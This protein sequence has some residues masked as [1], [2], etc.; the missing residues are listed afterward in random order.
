M[1]TENIQINIREDGAREVVININNIGK[2]ADKTA[3]DVIMLNQALE[4]MGKV[5]NKIKGVSLGFI[6]MADNVVLLEARLRM[7]TRTQENFLKSQEDIYKISQQNNVGLKETSQL[8]I[9]LFE[10]IS[11]LGG[12][13]KEVSTIVDA[14][15]TTLRISGATTRE[16][17]SATLQFSQAMASGRLNGDELRSLAEN[18]PRFMRLL[19]DGLKVTTGDLKK[20]GSEGKLTADV[21]G[22][23]LIK[24]LA[25]LK[26]EAAGLSNTVG[27]AM[28]DL[29]NDTINAVGAFDKLTGA[30]ATIAD[31][32]QGVS[33]VVF[34]LGNVFKD[35]LKDGTK[36]ATSGLDAMSISIKTI[37]MTL[38][39]VMLL[40]SDVSFIFKA[41]GRE[42]GGIAAQAVAFV[43]GDFDLVRGIRKEMVADGE[44][45]AVELKRYQD[46]ISKITSSAMQRREEMRQ[47][48]LNS[49]KGAEAKLKGTAKPVA[50]K[51]ADDRLA[52]M[53]DALTKEQTLFQK[54]QSIFEN[55]IKMLDV[56]HKEFNT[57]E[58]AFYNGRENARAEFIASE[59][60]SYEKERSI[61]ESFKPKTAKEVA[62]NQ[63]RLDKLLKQHEDFVNKMAS[64]RTDDELAQLA[65]AKRIQEQSDDAVSKYLSN[66]YET[67]QTLKE[68]TGA[69]ERNR[70][71]VERETV[72]IYEQAVANLK[73]NA[74]MPITEQHTQ[75]DIDA[76]NNMINFLTAEINLRRG[77]TTELE[78]QES[79]RFASRMA[80]QAIKDWER[81]GNSIADSLSDAFGSGGK[82]I[83]QMFKAFATGQAARLRSEKQIAAAKKLSDDDPQKIKAI[84][85]AQLAGAQSQ[86]KMYG[87]MANA[88]KGFFAEGSR[89]YRAMDTAVKVL[90]ASEVALSLIKGVNAVL[91]QGSG[92]PYTA[93]ARMAAMAAIVTGLGVALSGS[94]SGGGGMSAKQRQE[95]AGTGSVFG[96]SS[97]KS[98][99]IANALDILKNNS[100]IDLTYTSEMLKNLQSINTGINGLANVVIRGG[101]VLTGKVSAT[102]V[103]EGTKFNDITKQTGGLALLAGQVPKLAS[104][105][106]VIGNL[107]TKLFGI[108]TSVLDQGINDFSS[109]LKNVLDKGLDLQ[110]Y[111]QV[112]TTKKFLGITT[113]SK[114]STQL[115][116]LPDEVSDQFGKVITGIYNT[117]VQAASQL[118]LGGDA[119]TD[120]LQSFVVEID[121]ISVKGLTGEEIQKQFETVFSKFG[122]QL[123]AFGV[124]GLAQFQKVGEGYFETL[125]RIA[126]D[127]AN[128]NS[129]LAAI[130]KT[131]GQVGIESVV[132]RENLID[133][134]G[135]VEK[136]AQGTAY[137][138]DNFLS[139]AEK[140]APIAEH[141]NSAFGKIG[142]TIPKTV[143]D[144]KNLTLAQD[145]STQAGRDMYA[146]LIQLAPEFI[147]L[148]DA[149]TGAAD[150]TREAANALAETLMQNV[151]GAFES[152]QKAVG[153]EKE[154]LTAEY[155]ARNAAL[156]SQINAAQSNISALKS[157]SDAIHGALNSMQLTEQALYR[158]VTAQQ[159]IKGAIATVKGGKLPDMDTLRTA[160]TTVTQNSEDLFASATDFRRDFY[161]TAN[162][163]AE[164]GEVTDT[165]MVI[166]Q[167]SLD[168]LIAQRDLLKAT[169]DA[170][171]AR[172]DKE[173]EL[174]Q[175]QVDL[176]NGINEKSTSIVD[177]I[178]SLASAIQS[179]MAN[180]IAGAGA[181]AAGAYGTYLGR[182]PEAGAVDYWKGQAMQGVDIVGAIARSD[183]SKIN[184]LYRTMLGR[185]SEVAGMNFWLQKLRSGTS[186]DQISQGFMESDE[187]KR[188]HAPGFANGG[189]FNGGLRV[190]GGGGPELEATGA[191]RIHNTDE[192]AGMMG[193]DEI[194]AMLALIKDSLDEL[195][196]TSTKTADNTKDTHDILDQAT[197]GG[198]AMLVQDIATLT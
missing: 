65:T 50:A 113:S 137:F 77:I 86:L 43:K 167:K 1:T 24:S 101:G 106:P 189:M 196:K 173:L 8:Y 7:V 73:L 39:T 178:A 172:L 195:N 54:E 83:G 153:A 34:S 81:V 143:E 78:K 165:Q 114:I 23:V 72:A 47:E 42:I 53:Q 129:I 147:Q 197:A 105:L 192:L 66:Q 91:T 180:P 79:L 126:N 36:V 128:V 6:E 154:R 35:E 191:S 107:V 44:Q 38:E 119:F 123:A 71:A 198:S 145:L 193:T 12:G 14:F 95:T 58:D 46:R 40:A 186:I 138:R 171:M 170:E 142:L 76:A 63:L 20:M 188:L 88:A 3:K 109:T 177:A 111:V 29:S 68:T 125:V 187:Y 151:A 61:I 60:S 10:P 185:E 41:I 104:K 49:I 33:L 181:A 28:S 130:G 150:A 55:R 124:E 146:I 69:R 99:S 103:V 21:I 127:Y 194:V 92:D 134:F 116:N 11:R 80:D 57:S 5:W 98:T 15:S 32:I 163:L 27:G 90:H 166:A 85:E 115:A 82:A 158:R 168:T 74:A 52:R 169:Y 120:K 183:E 48:E 94:V 22:N 117:V 18:S 149:M 152:L 62:Q 155:E 67:L 133:L 102:G 135:G 157:A 139:A 59:K 121:K 100:S 51:G 110:S 37:G 25:D 31:M 87:D 70:S 13:I 132:A 89:G 164:L 4:L 30:T 162:D 141:L 174:A 112:Q 136:L 160:L 122:D 161:L 140:I 131:M 97:A 93:F 179:A 175:T 184:S 64:S 176:L 118:G 45:A 2:A 182:Q 190:V 148:Q 16:A 159:T 9:R 19:A 156:S 96:D 108:T 75:A 26:K 17:A 56:Y 84:Q 144:Y